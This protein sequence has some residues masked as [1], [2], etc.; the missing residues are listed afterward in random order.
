MEFDIEVYTKKI[1]F[2]PFTSAAIPHVH[3]DEIE[4]IEFSG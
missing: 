2:F 1:N 4:V 3:N